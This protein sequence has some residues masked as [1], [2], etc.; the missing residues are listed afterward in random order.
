MK[1][2][3]SAAKQAGLIVSVRDDVTQQP[4]WK[5]TQAGRDWWKANGS[6]KTKPTSRECR[7]I[8]QP[9]Q[10]RSRGHLP[11]GRCPSTNPTSA[12]AAPPAAADGGDGYEDLLAIISERDAT[13]AQL[14]SENAELQKV[15][16]MMD[17]VGNDRLQILQSQKAQIEAL[18]K[19][20]RITADPSPAMLETVAPSAYLI[21]AHKRKLRLLTREESAIKA[22]VG[23]VRNGS[24]YAEVFALTPCGSASRAATY[25][26]RGE[27]IK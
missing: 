19:Q 18:E 15:I 9:R 20:T 24:H 6:A 27:A 12:P 13:V 4:A 7:C 17:K 23:A 25:A 26:P 22:A 2:N 21:R 8:K 14:Q 10:Q 11:G 16:G 1:N 3:T 5:L